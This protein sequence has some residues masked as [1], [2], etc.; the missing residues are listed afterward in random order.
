M[1]FASFDKF[2]SLPRVIRRDEGFG[3]P[4][5]PAIGVWRDARDDGRVGGEIFIST[6]SLAEEERVAR[7]TGDEGI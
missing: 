7:N 3:M 5:I 4:A 6:F 1:S 2:D